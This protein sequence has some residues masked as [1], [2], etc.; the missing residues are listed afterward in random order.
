MSLKTSPGW[1]KSLK[2]AFKDGVNKDASAAYF[3]FANTNSEGKPSVRTVVFRGFICENYPKETDADQ[4]LK[5]DALLSF[6]THLKS[7]KIAELK[8][9][10]NFE[11]SWW[12]PSVR[13]Q[14]RIS[15]QAHLIVSPEYVKDYPHPTKLVHCETS[16]PIDWEFQRSKF[17]SFMS[18]SLKASF[19]WPPPGK[20]VSK[21]SVFHYEMDESNAEAAKSNF[22][23]VVLEPLKVDVVSL[24]HRDHRRHLY[25]LST[26]PGISDENA[27]SDWTFQELNP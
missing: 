13:E 8:K 26:G 14:Y 20:P 27:A 2:A 21:D 9:N 24:A 12:F 17:F 5:T 15:G 16:N 18:P 10:N 6:T 25:S 4:M 3:S 1:L 7:N 23:L 11:I 19:L 22:V